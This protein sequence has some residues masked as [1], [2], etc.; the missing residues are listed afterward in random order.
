[1][2]GFI[3]FSSTMGTIDSL[4]F[5]LTQ[6][7]LDDLCEKYYS[8]DAVYPKLLG[9]NARI[10]RS[11]TNASVF[12]LDVPWH[13]GKTLRK[14]PPPTPDEFSAEVCDFLTNNPA[15][16]K[17]FPKAFLYLVGISRYYTLDE[18]CYPTFWDDKDK[19]GEGEVPL[20]ELT[21]DRV[22]PMAGVDDRG[23]AAAMGNGNDDVN[24]GSDDATATENTKQSGH[25]VR[26]GGIEILA[27]DEAQALVPDKPKKFRKRKIADGAG[28]SGLPPKKLR[29]DHSTS[30]DAGAITA[31]KSIV[32][33]QD[34]LD[35][36]TLVTEI[37]VTSAATVPFD[38]SSVTPTP[39]H[40]GGK[41]ADSISAANVRTKRPVGR[42]IVSRSTVLI[43]VVLTAA[44][45]T[46]VVAGTSIYLDI[47]SEAL[48]QAYVPK[49]DVLNDSL[50]DDPNV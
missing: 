14:D 2:L 41:D 7:A 9:P 25:V 15:L 18:N 19:G 42:S 8:P 49:W 23:N 17:K 44:V 11:P 38:T 50:M 1:M 32:A 33:L 29:E 30:R 12:P 37:S 20:L 10:R 39:E 5:V 47:D 35:K 48:R 4:K 24:E 31:K 36:S 28:G 21:K 22:V 40:E 16:F 26:L 3:F 45:A 13:S 6:S 46:S 43:L 27:D 34:L